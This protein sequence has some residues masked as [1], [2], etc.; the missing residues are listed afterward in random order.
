MW[1]PR[2]DGSDMMS[3]RMSHISGKRALDCS[4]LAL[5]SPIQHT[6]HSPAS[7]EE[8]ST[9]VPKNSKWHNIPLSRFSCRF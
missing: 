8:F 7:F 1:R 6:G 5:M 2:K 3:D 4:T 9:A